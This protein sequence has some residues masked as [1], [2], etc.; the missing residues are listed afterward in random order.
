V[1]LRLRQISCEKS[2]AAT[3]RY[4]R[5]PVNAAIRIGMRSHPKKNMDAH[6]VA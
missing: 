3:V 2:A 4:L 5:S 6:I 1:R